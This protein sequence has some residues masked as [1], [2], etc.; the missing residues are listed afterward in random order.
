MQVQLEVPERGG[1]RRA[2]ERAA[3]QGIGPA[4]ALQGSKC[5]SSTCRLTFPWI[6]Q[7]VPDT[8]G[9]VTSELGTACTGQLP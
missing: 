3:S 5:F 2:E 1:H 7:I 9:P 4:K 6:L 8:V